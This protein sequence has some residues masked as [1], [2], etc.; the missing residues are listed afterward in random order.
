MMEPNRRRLGWE[1]VAIAAFAALPPTLVALGALWQAMGAKEQA[2]VTHAA[3]NGQTAK[4]IESVK[5]ES[6]AKAVLTEKQAQEEKEAAIA[7][8][9]ADEKAGVKPKTGDK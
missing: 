7:K 5:G 9:L 6:A 2:I 4:L 1:H 8:A 3:V